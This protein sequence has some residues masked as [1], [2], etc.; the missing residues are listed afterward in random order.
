MKR[1]FAFAVLLT[2]VLVT[3]CAASRNVV[4]PA[5]PSGSEA[6][7]VES[8]F[9]TTDY[10][11]LEPIA[12]GAARHGYTNPRRKLASYDAILLER[13]TIWRDQDQKE[14]VES[15]DFQN[16]VDDIYTLA[17]R[18]FRKT[19]ALATKAGP[20]V[21]RLRIALV[22]LDSPDDKLDVYVSEGE[23]SKAIADA[24]LPAGIREFGRSAWVEA[25]ILDSV[26]KEPIVA[27]VDRVRD[28]IPRSGP[29][30][31]W[32]ELHQALEA[33]ATQAAGRIAALR[34]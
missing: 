24:E 21:G 10:A 14:P 6:G 16:V 7:F 2:A 30:K 34:K 26:T 33:W 8:G 20:G 23:P 32:R 5:P 22:A 15:E 4:P 17:S 12:P 9:L 19:F 28:V 18:E 3:A 1:R 25:E 31:T 13:I 29:I 27:V 11:L